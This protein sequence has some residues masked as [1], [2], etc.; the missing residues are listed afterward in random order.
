MQGRARRAITLFGAAAALHEAFGN[1]PPPIYRA[2]NNRGI[3]T[4]RARIDESTF[5]AAWGAGQAMTLEQATEY[6]L[7][8]EDAAS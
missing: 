3:A 1:P 2:D 4:A 6:A 7:A 5:S 8:S